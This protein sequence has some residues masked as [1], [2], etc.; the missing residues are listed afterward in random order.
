[1]LLLCITNVKLFW[2]D[3]IAFNVLH[4][5]V[6][7]GKKYDYILKPIHYTKREYRFFFFFLIEGL[8]WVFLFQCDESYFKMTLNSE[9][10][11]F[12]LCSASFS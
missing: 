12:I 7:S 8:W 3:F 5:L 6:Q 4:D 10:K 2:V 11:I 9:Y 1:M